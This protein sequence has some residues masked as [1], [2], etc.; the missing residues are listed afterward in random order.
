MK[1]KS[2]EEI[3][4]E[5][6]LNNWETFEEFAQAELFDLLIHIR[7]DLLHQAKYNYIVVEHPHQRKACVYY[8]T[9]PSYGKEEEYFENAEELNRYINHLTIEDNIVFTHNLDDLNSYEI[10]CVDELPKDEDERAK[11]IYDNQGR[12]NLLSL[13]EIKKNI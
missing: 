9:M 10:Y 12:H 1:Y 8:V 5:M 6:E 13:E 7:E 4:K 11:F 3:E 2:Y